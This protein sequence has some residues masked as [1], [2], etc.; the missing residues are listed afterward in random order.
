MLSNNRSPFRHVCI[1]HSGRFRCIG[2]NARIYTVSLSVL[3]GR[4]PHQQEASQH[5]G[6]GWLGSRS[7]TPLSSCVADIPFSR[8]PRQLYDLW[9]Q[10]PSILWQLRVNN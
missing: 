1:G 5:L 4:L 3:Y 8:H 9:K 6:Q 7:P 2:A 10:Y